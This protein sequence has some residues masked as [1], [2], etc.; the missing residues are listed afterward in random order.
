MNLGNGYVKAAKH[1]NLWQIDILVKPK[2]MIS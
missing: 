1:E 2:K